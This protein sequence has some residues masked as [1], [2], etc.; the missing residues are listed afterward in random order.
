MASDRITDEFRPGEM[1]DWVTSREGDTLVKRQ[2][3][4]IEQMG[5]EAIV[6][7]G[8]DSRDGSLARHTAQL[9]EL[10]RVVAP[11]FL[12]GMVVRS[13]P[14]TPPTEQQTANRLAERR[15]TLKQAHSTARNAQETVGKA[16]QLADRAEAHLNDARSR[17]AQLR[18]EQH[19]SAAE[20]EAT[21]RRGENPSYSNGHDYSATRELVSVSEQALTKF[22]SELALANSNLADA[23][24][25]VRRAA[26]DVIASLIEREAESL[27]ALET[28]AARQRA[29]LVNVSRWWPS[30]DLG[31][32]RLAPAAA[33]LLEAV[34]N[35]GE[36]P[37]VRMS[38]GALDT[39]KEVFSQLVSG[40][41]DADFKLEE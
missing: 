27:R 19:A 14:P 36:L 32:F 33:T 3:K 30:A 1:L 20:F 37:V 40:D 29:E 22:Q 18:A 11:S 21:I 6:G 24:G 10:H 17:L 35:Y 25:N 2:V 5:A 8:Q 12:P 23:L 34:P 4:F 28:Q 13:K 38:S 41:A 16:G 15:E 31:P 26:A 39:W 9:S 7:F